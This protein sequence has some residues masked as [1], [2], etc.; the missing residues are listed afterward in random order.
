MAVGDIY[1]TLVGRWLLLPLPVW[2][3][4]QQFSEEILSEYN[5]LMNVAKQI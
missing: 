4:V 3:H 1:G 5:A 2:F